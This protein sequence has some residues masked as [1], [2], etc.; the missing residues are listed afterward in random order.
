[1]MWIL[2]TIVFWI[3]SV[4]SVFTTTQWAVFPLMIIAAF[5]FG[6]WIW[7]NKQK[8]TEKGRLI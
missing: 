3:A 5:F 1:M 8:K 6:I 2:L 4:A 7:K